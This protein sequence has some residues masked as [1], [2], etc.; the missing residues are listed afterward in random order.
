M[1]L[2]AA[3]R[4]EVSRGGMPVLRAVS[5]ALQ[6]GELVGLLGANGAGKSTLLGALAG[7]LSAGAGRVTLDGVDVR[8]LGPRRLAR[9]RAVLPQRPALDFDL[10][11]ADVVEMGM[12]P[13]PGLPAGAVADT[14]ARALALAGASAFAGRRYLQL[15]GGE[16]QRVQ[17]ARVL[18]QCLAGREPGE[19]RALL[20]DEPVSGL[21]PLHQHRLLSGAAQLARAE[22]VGVLAVLHDVNLAARWCDRLLLLAGGGIAA[23]GAPAEVLTAA[24]L[25][26]VFGMPATLLP[27]PGA[28]GRPLVVFG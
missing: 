10:A 5:F 22:R 26:R 8:E 16:Q 18:A 9:R 23:C 6:A 19:A 4:I 11:V 27:H 1:T 14:A 21:D 24:T 3:D 28:P 17:Y 12:Y 25:E 15:S 20:L 7:E 13:F 2:L